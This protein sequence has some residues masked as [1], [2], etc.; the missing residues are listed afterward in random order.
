MSLEEFTEI[1]VNV[2]DEIRSQIQETLNILETT[3]ACQPEDAQI[4][5]ATPQPLVLI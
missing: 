2:S 4:F 3:H 1:Y 5:H